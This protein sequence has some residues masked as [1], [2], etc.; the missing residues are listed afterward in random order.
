MRKFYLLI[1]LFCLMYHQALPQFDEVYASTLKTSPSN[2]TRLESYSLKSGLS[3][4]EEKFKVSIAYKDEWVENKTVQKPSSNLTTVEAALDEL[5]ADTDLNYK[6]AGSSFY[7]ISLKSAHSKEEEVQTA[8]LLLLPE[9]SGDVSASYPLFIFED[10]LITSLRLNEMAIRAILVSG[11]VTD[12][13]GAGFPGVNVLVKG[14]TTGTSTDTNGKFSL[15]VPDENA[16]LVFSSIGYLSQEVTVGSRTSIDI[17]MQAD[18]K[19]LEEVVVTALGI[20]K[21]TKRL[22]YATSSVTPSQITEN[23]TVNF[24]SGLQGKMAGVNI[25]PMGTGPAGTTKIRIRGQSSI[26]AQN[27]PLIVVNGVP[28]NNTTFGVNGDFQGQN[29]SPDPIGVT[30]GGDGLTSINPDDIESMTVL[31]GGAAA[32]LYGSRAQNGVI[33]IT[34]KSG[35][36]TKGLGVE[37]NTN[38]TSDTP[39]DFTDFQYEY[40]QGENGIRSTNAN[41]T[42]GVWSFGEKFQPGMTNVLFDG[43]TVPYEPV[44]GRI[45]KFYRQGN[46]LTNTITVSNGGKNGGINLSIANMDNTSIQ[47]NSGFNRKT[48]NL[49]FNQKITEKLVVTGNIAYSVEKNTNPPIVAGQDNSTPVVLWTLSNSMPFDLLEEKQFDANGNEFVYS[50]FRN[51]TNPYISTTKKFENIT[52][53]RVFGNVT[54]KYN[55]TDWLYVQGRLGLDY[56]ARA[57][58]FNNPTGRASNAPAPAGFVNGTF[59]QE[60]L[61]SNEINADFLMGA[62]KSYTSGFAF[63]ATFGGN[64]RYSRFD[65][66]TVSVQD[67]VVRD[68]YTVANGR[69]KDPR[70][71]LSEVKINS[72]YGAGELSYKGY[73][74]L[75]LTA[76]NDWFSTLSPANRSILY[77]SANASFIFSQAFQGLPDWLSFGKI[78]A[79]YS[80]VGSDNAVGPYASSL[81]YG[82]NN[83]LFPNPT[84]ASQPVGSIPS[85]VVPNTNLKPSRVAETEFGLEVKLFE[86]RIGVDL[87][88]YDKTTSDQILAAQVSDA[89]GYTSQLINIGRSKNSGIELLLTATPVKT[90]NFNWDISFNFATNNTE[91]LDLGPGITQIISGGSAG[92]N[93][94]RQTVGGELNTLFASAYLRDAEGNQVFDSNSGRPLRAPQ[95]RLIGTTIPKYF[96][97]IF[98]SFTYKGIIVSA[99]IDFK[100]GHFLGS[101]T[102]FNVY[103][104]G[105]HKSTLVGREE[106][107]VTGVG[108]NQQ[109]LPNTVKTPLQTFYE[110]VNTSSIREEFAY[111]AGFW[112]FRQLSIGYDF[113]KILPESTF[114]K[115]LRLNAVANN[116]ALLKK[117]VPNIDPEQLNSSSDLEQGLEQT[118]LPTTRNIGFN[119]NLKF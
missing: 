63:D 119:L 93:S 80:Q 69:V 105:L 7:V 66:N 52:R 26:S 44:T 11:T 87:T 59:T 83:N 43:V 64:Q 68:L 42:S 65:R 51:R 79:G 111:N 22:G 17:S 96:G 62:T 90:T 27:G 6:K 99:L 39:L 37:L 102:N 12:E 5:L 81:F 3:L 61:R 1:G 58:D 103:R 23:R 53:N 29:S 46:T 25:T 9:L 91:V 84:G 18:V 85:G 101:Q 57:R 28:I 72:F 109:G 16:V 31:K 56:F 77:P 88:Y 95:A 35:T 50:R 15:S 89:S 82:V 13:N 73:L 110:T 20:K 4:L 55:L 75:N 19:A 71:D 60:V 86:N 41:P 112:R 98:N 92:A 94:L 118:G 24:M 40:G 33:M 115:G 113:T 36:S 67:F 108:V 32:A 106:N 2:A 49:G 97:G 104:H 107:L 70:Y 78:R 117:W 76:R 8:S 45:N 30:D 54:A 74:Y 10:K 34:T 14:T 47:P 116:V 100:L 48:L 38:F 21:E 114:I